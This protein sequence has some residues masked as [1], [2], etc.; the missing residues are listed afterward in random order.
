MEE[1]IL[2]SIHEVFGYTSI[3]IN[4]IEENQFD[5]EAFANEN[6]LKFKRN[7]FTV[8]FSIDRDM[9]TVEFGHRPDDKTM[10]RM[11]KEQKGKN[12]GANRTKSRN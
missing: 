4:W 5:Y 11:I 2:I 1:R 7:V 9:H 12:H 6:S 10:K 3:D 8:S